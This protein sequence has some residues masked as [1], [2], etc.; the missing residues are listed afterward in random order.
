MAIDG[1]YDHRD[2][3][4]ARGTV[5]SFAKKVCSIERPKSLSSVERQR[6]Q[7]IEARKANLYVSGIPNKWTEKDLRTTF[8][9]FGKII[10]SKLWYASEENE[11]NCKFNSG[12]GF[13]QFSNKK[14]ADA[15]IVE[16]NGVRLDGMLR[17]LIVKFANAAS[18]NR[19]M[20]QPCDNIYV[21]GLPDDIDDMRLHKLFEP[22]G[23]V[24]S[25]IVLP[26][27]SVHRKYTGFIKFKQKLDA[28]EALK[29]MH[30]YKIPD[31]NHTISCSWAKKSSKP[32]IVNRPDGMLM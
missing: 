15:A 26:K 5:F 30:R 20:T 8:A 31:T 17:S 24:E 29:Q 18:Q 1:Q 19:N 28:L 11:N 2:T 7:D 10:S 27:K 6:R 4:R 22:F 25:V 9:A 3:D 14:E 16:M 21:S 13:I 12:S 32:I 23:E